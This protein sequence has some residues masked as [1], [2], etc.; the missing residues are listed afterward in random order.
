MK[1]EPLTEKQQEGIPAPCRKVY[2][3][4]NSNFSA[5]ITKTYQPRKYL[6]TLWHHVDISSKNLQ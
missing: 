2:V 4:A 6:L 1:G 3:V 5:S